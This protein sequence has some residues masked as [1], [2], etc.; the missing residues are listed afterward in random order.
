MPNG[1]NT[2]PPRKKNSQE[3]ESDNKSRT[4]RQAGA[5]AHLWAHTWKWMNST[6]LASGKAY[7]KGTQPSLLPAAS[8]P[9]SLLLVSI[10]LEEG[11]EEIKRLEL[12]SDLD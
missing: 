3:T 7:L 12:G 5:E 6:S 10:L 9:P 2:P 1:Q 11:G 4:E 8:P